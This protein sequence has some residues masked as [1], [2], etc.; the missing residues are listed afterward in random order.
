MAIEHSVKVRQVSKD[1]YHK[2]DYEVM[3]LVF[4]IHNELGRLHDEKIYEH[5]LRRRCEAAGFETRTGVPVL[6][7]YKEFVKTYYLDLIIDSAVVYELKTVAAIAARHRSQLLHYL[8]LVDL[9]YGKLVN[10]RP[11]SVEHEFITT[12]LTET[13][14]ARFTIENDGW[15]NHQERSVF[16]RQLM[17]ELLA[18]WGAFLDVGL[19]REAVTFFLGGE[20]K[21]CLPVD[22][23]RDSH[24]LGSQRVDLLTSDTA[25]EITAIRMGGDSYEKHLSRFLAHTHLRRIQWVNLNRHRITFK[26]IQ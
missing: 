11:P 9:L 2:I 26:T 20:E 24:I 8:M 14:R 5:E 10:L 15:D 19:F 22:V 6:V 17:E 3:R 7:R 1:E 23:V 13:G 16:F 25:F 12:G 21:V 4:S 18:E